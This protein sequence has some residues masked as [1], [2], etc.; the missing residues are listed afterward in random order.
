MGVSRFVGF[1][2]D[3]YYENLEFP[4]EEKKRPYET[5]DELLLVRGMNETLYEALKDF[6]TIYGTGKV[7]INTASR[8]VLYALGLSMGAV[9]KILIARQGQDRQEATGDDYVFEHFSQ[10]EA[11]V[12]L[13]N[14]TRQELREIDRVY[15]RQEIGFHSSY[16]NIPVTADYR[17]E[18]KR[19]ECVY[20]RNDGKMV[21]WKE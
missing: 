19:I 7:N 3:A 1:Y 17:G 2:S 21:Y 18:T 8:P 13:V 14:L 15:G 4:Y 12:S 6:L 11:L 9:N 20:G 10:I 5:L 16:F